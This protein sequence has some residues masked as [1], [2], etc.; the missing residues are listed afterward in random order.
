M[1]EHQQHSAE[2]LRTLKSNPRGLSITDI[3]KAVGLNRNSTAKYLDILHYTG[4]I[5]MMNVGRAKLYYPS[6]RVPISALLD[7][8]S[9]LILSLDGEMNILD[10]NDNFLKFF[11]VK[12]DML[13]D[14]SITSVDLP[15]FNTREQISSLQ[16]AL[17]GKD[18]SLD[19][20]VHMGNDLHF[21]RSKLIPTIMADGNNG[22]TAI[23]ENVDERRVAQIL[24]RQS[25]QK[26]R[27]IYESSMDAM[28]ITDNE[29]IF[30]CND[31]TKDMFGCSDT[32]FIRRKFHFFSPPTQ[33]GGEGSQKLLS[34]HMENARQ[35]GMARF[36]WVHRRFDGTDFQTETIITPLELYGKRSLLIV[37]RDISERKNMEAA[38]REKEE[39]YRTLF[40]SLPDAVMILDEGKVIQCNESTLK[41]FG[42]PSRDEMIGELVWDLSPPFQPGGEVSRTKAMRLLREVH[43]KG[44]LKFEWEHLRRGD[45]FIAE[46]SLVMTTLNEVP[47]IQATVRDIT[48]LRAVQEELL[49][50]EAKLNNILS[51]IRGAFIGVIDTNL[52]YDGFWG[53][54]ELDEVYGLESSELIGSSAVDFA[55]SEKVDE[56][57]DLLNR[58][59][60]TGESISIEVEGKLPSGTFYQD[61]TFSPYRT[62]DGCIHGIVQFG[63]DTT[64]KQLMLRKLRDT[65]RLY[66]LLD[67]NISDVILTVDMEMNITFITTSILD[68]TGHDPKELVGKKMVDLI[69]SRSLED[70]MGPMGGELREFLEG[71]KKDIRPLDVDLEIVRRDRSSFLGTSRF[72]A[73]RGPDK[74]PIGMICI[75]REVK[76]E[77]GNP[78]L[79][80]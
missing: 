18:S 6:H 8:S 10:V 47:V 20:E 36:D 23:L 28:I 33:P 32:E 14:R 9:D 74:N 76:K 19:L 54:Q 49:Q 66:H 11:H 53:S 60:N 26:F 12:K 3:S 27:S 35:K 62:P 39:V 51:S 48:E 34:L 44:T 57:K 75:I 5:E 80:T 79:R 59:M 73:L 69:T 30:E 24:I 61:M 68:L 1:E 70:L 2:I 41:V 71:R 22:I 13:I 56:F 31:A 16:R 63:K 38:I 15:V 58:V 65:E 21:F 45:P 67:D 40:E 72:I 55:P 17:M 4:R 42:I 46:I 52:V 77:R 64:E 7:F 37:I 29:N 25:E 78:L 50:N 43:E